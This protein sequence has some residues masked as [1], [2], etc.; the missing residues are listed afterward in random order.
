MMPNALAKL[1]GNPIRVC[2]EQEPKAESR[3]ANEANV[4]DL[5]GW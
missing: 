2:P 3:E 4:H 5:P 1:Q